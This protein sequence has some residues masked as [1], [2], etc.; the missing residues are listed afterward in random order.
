MTAAVAVAGYALGALIVWGLLGSARIPASYRV[1]LAALAWH[2]V[3][4][5]YAVGLVAE[6][7]SRA[8]LALGLGDP[9]ADATP[10]PLEMGR[11][12]EDPGAR[13]ITNDDDLDAYAILAA[14]ARG[15]MSAGT[16]NK[17][18]D[19]TLRRREW[20]DRNGGAR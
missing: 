12:Y 1:V 19:D 20:R 9:V 3:V 14:E 11:W 17:E 6:V 10:E 16:P 7:M 2:A 8:G 18:D 5:L 15:L 13:Y 4:A